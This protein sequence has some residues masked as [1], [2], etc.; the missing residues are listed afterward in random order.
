MSIRIVL[1]VNVE[2]MLTFPCPFHPS[3]LLPREKANSVQMIVV[4]LLNSAS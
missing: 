2:V 3:L 4:L 1:D